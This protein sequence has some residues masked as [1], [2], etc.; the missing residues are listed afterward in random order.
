MVTKSTAN[1]FNELIDRSGLIKPDKLEGLMAELQEAGVDCS[2]PKEIAKGLI[3]KEAL[4][5][6][7][8]EFLLKGKHKGFFVG[9]YRLLRLL[10]KGGMGT[11]YLAEHEMMRRRCALKVLPS[12]LNSR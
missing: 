2:S 12:N 6:W 7:Q 11:V 8:A 9:P 4:T 3:E 5:R 1:A 10:G